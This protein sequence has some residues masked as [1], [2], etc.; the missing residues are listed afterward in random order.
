MAGERSFAH[1]HTHTEYSMLDGAARIGELVNAAVAD[2][3]PALGITDHGNMY[4]VLDFYA[5]GC[6]RA[7]DHAGGGHRGVHG[8]GLPSRA[9]GATGQ[10]GRHRRGRRG[11]GEALLPPDAAG[12]DHGGL[13]Q[14]HEVVLGR[15]PRGL[16]LQARVGLGAPRAVPPR[17]DRHDRMPRWRGAAGAAGRR[18]R[19]G[20]QAGRSAPGHLRA[21][22]PLRGAP[23]PRVGRPEPDQPGTRPRSPA[24]WAPPCSPPTTATT[25]IAQT[26]RPR[27]SVVRADGC[28]HRRPRRGSS[29]RA[30]ST[31]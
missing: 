6:R 15:L 11:R 21:G 24:S 4:G 23:G 18:R 27:R 29:S 10:G 3:Q 25:P 16:L 12:R 2:G 8:G 14:P 19:A 17:S 7:G 31:I 30:R 22:Q 1:L 5:Q 20:A 26:C 28:P 9:A 13:R